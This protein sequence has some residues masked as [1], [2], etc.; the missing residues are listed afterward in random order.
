MVLVMTMLVVSIFLLIG[1]AFAYSAGVQRRA[2]LNAVRELERDCA[3]LS[4]LNYARAIIEADAATGDVDTLD[5]HWAARD[6]TVEVGGVA[7]TIRIE[8]EEQ[9][10]NVNLAVQAPQDPERTPDLRPALRALIRAAGGCDQDFDAIVSAIQPDRPI[11]L[12][13]A[14]RAV[15]GL[16]PRLF[17]SSPTKPA[18]DELLATHARQVNLNTAAETVLEALWGPTGPVKS[19]LERRAAQ[20]F[21]AKMDIERFLD[22]IGAPEDVRRTLP[23][24]DVRSEFFRVY[25]VPAGALPGGALEALVH[26]TGDR[27]EVLWVRPA[28]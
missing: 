1:C 14:L 7:C 23:L 22:S 20:P 25:V 2:A 6:L 18:L 5:E 21:R 24:L 11:P 28:G 8:D 26:R 9:R 3:A 4:A 13:S 16:D 10:L 12:I 27:A 17:E 19:V 15:P